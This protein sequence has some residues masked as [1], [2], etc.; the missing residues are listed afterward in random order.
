[1]K[2]KF[3]KLLSPFQKTALNMDHG[4]FN[5]KHFVLST[6]QWYECTYLMI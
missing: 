4:T 3:E 5:M 2:V 1:M 6:E